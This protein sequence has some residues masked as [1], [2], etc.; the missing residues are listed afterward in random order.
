[1]TDV[2]ILGTVL[3]GWA[4]TLWFLVRLLAQIA[5]RLRRPREDCDAPRRFRDRDCL[6]PP[7]DVRARPDPYIYSQEW[8]ASRG[9]AVTWDNPDFTLVDSA[10]GA[11]ADRLAL[12][13]DH[14][15]TVESAIHNNSFMA[16][17]ATRVAFEV[18]GFGI[19]TTAV[20][21]LPTAV[22]DVPA[23]GTV[24]A[25][26]QWHTP[27]SGGHNCLRALIFHL[28][29]A[30]P[31]NNVGQHNTDVAEPQ[32]PERALVFRLG[33]ELPRRQEVVLR[34]NA[35]QLPQQ[36]ECPGTFRDRSSV[37]YLRALQERNDPR[38]FPVP[39]ALAAKLSHTA[40]AADQELPV[41]VTLTFGA[42]AAAGPRQAVNVDAYAGERLVG[43]IT[44]YVGGEVG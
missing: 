8:L 5:R 32:S 7:V 18:R 12:L 2:P 34:M 14:D 3:R 27:A 15:Y 22:V 41:E 40:I 26:T 38:R 4:V 11:V 43:G 9:L 37:T 29:D 23:F 31:L 13:P 39:E 36:A 30:N 6:T 19:G 1:M 10:S 35:Y 28:D 33:P 21:A 17:F 20:A 44:A 42:S 25:R 24:L 16:A